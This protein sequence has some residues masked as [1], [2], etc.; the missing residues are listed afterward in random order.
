MRAAALLR[1]A[2]P[3]LPRLVIA[4]VIAMLRANAHAAPVVVDNEYVLHQLDALDAQLSVLAGQKPGAGAKSGAAHAR[5]HGAKTGAASNSAA[6]NSAVSDGATTN[7]QATNGQ[8][9]S[10]ALTPA[11]KAALTAARAIITQLRGQLQGAV[12]ASSSQLYPL[13]PQRF[14]AL[15]Q[16][17]RMTGIPHERLELIAATARQNHFTCDQTATLLGVLVLS[18]DRFDA[19]S[20]LAPQIVDSQ[21]Y[22]TVLA[23]FPIPSDAERAKALLLPS[24]KRREDPFQLEDAP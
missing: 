16:K 22:Q 11:Q 18:S 5:K 7:G 24:T 19:L 9:P 23:L 1:W 10:P 17:L 14:D 20:Q 15:L 12:P 6:S 21:N 3:A 8:A 4:I 13:D 2:Q